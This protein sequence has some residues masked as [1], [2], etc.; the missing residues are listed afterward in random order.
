M[1]TLFL[2]FAL[3][4]NGYLFGAEDPGLPG[5]DPD[6][7]IDDGLYLFLTAG[8]LYGIRYMVK[9]KELRRKS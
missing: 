7:P 2:I 6:V 1:K 3:L 5:G 9:E 4:F 8:M